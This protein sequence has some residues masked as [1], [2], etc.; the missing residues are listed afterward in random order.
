MTQVNFSYIIKTD[1]EQNESF[2][3]KGHPNF[4]IPDFYKED[5]DIWNTSLSYLEKLENCELYDQDG[6]EVTYKK[7][8][9]SSGLT[10]CIYTLYGVQ[11][12][13][14]DEL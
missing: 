7:V 10:K 12:T 3:Y 9:D 13:E 1:D 8:I 11:F 2:F 14:N 4:L 5:C 6:G